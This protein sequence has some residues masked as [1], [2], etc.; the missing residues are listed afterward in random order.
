MLVGLLAQRQPRALAHRVANVAEHEQ[1]AE[2]GAGKA[3]RVVRLAR[4]E[5]VGEALRRVLD[6]I[7]PSPPPP[8]SLSVSAGS[9]ATWRAAA[10]S[11]KLLARSASLAASACSISR[12]ATCALN[13]SSSARSASRTGSS[14]MASCALRRQPAR[15]HVNR[16]RRQRGRDRQRRHEA[17]A[18]HGLHFLQLRWRKS[19][20]VAHASCLGQKSGRNARLGDNL[21]AASDPPP[22]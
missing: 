11:T 21:S 2:R 19:F 14:A 6:E 4:H 18:A 1:I 9:S 10:S 16:E 8:P 15:H 17:R 22:T 3:R 20:S 12:V 5:A 7:A 13:F